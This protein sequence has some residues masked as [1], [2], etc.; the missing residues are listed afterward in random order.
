MYLYTLFFF[1][2][3]FIFLINQL[4]NFLS[5][6]NAIIQ[7]ENDFLNLME[8]RYALFSLFAKFIKD[9]SFNAQIKNSQGINNLLILE[10]SIN[11]MAESVFIFINHFDGLKNGEVL[12]L[13]QQLVVV[14]NQYSALKSDSRSLE[15]R[16]FSYLNRLDFRILSKYIHILRLSKPFFIIETKGENV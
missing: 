2:I 10:Q 9:D 7:Y 1:S 16:Y 14:E 15:I 3:L 5:F 4:G 6:K 8:R 13:E 12:D 11:Q